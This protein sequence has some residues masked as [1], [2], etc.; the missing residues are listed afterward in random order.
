M[1]LI[2]GKNN[3]KVSVFDRGLQY[4]DGVFET[5]AYRNGKP[6]FLEQH[7]ERLF[8]S[9]DLLSINFKQQD[10]LLS[11]LALVCEAL[12]QEQAV[13]KI[14]VTRGEGSR[15]YFSDNSALPTRIISTHSHPTFPEYYQKDGV[16]LRFC[17]QTLSINSRLAGIKH[18]N[19]LEQVLARN[20]WDDPDIAEGI[21]SDDDDNIIEGTMSNLFIVASDKLYTPVVTRAGIAGVVRAQVIQLATRSGIS[22]QEQI[23]TKKALAEADEVFVCN[24]VIGIWPV[25]AI[26]NKLYPVGFI[27]QFLQKA[28]AECDK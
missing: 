3:D 8:T 4:G 12:Q 10:E 23:I 13:I 25:S 5:I 18:L 19:R 27:T 2:N 17:E 7:L 9:C 14:T 28:L 16:L 26:S 21:M 20:E 1:V 11:E 6:E 22:V 24:S 15:G